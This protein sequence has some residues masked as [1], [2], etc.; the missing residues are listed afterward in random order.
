MW[1][2]QTIQWSRKEML[3]AVWRADGKLE[4]ADLRGHTP[5]LKRDGILEGD[6]SKDIASTRAL[7]GD[8]AHP[9]CLGIGRELLRS[10]WNPLGQSKKIEPV[11]RQSHEHGRDKIKEGS[12]RSCGYQSEWE[13][14]MR[15]LWYIFLCLQHTNASSILPS[16]ENY[17]KLIKIL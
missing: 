3:A 6:D 5:E 9:W 11:T 13:E 4:H 1:N 17:H 8:C 16:F 7:K 14:E 10:E 2:V 15:Q 12:W